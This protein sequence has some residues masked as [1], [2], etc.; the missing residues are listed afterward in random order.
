MKIKNQRPGDYLE[1]RGA[2]EALCR[3]KETR[4]RTNEHIV[5]ESG[6]DE[7]VSLVTTET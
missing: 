3:Q 1:E 7:V 5:D 2:Y 6:C 4:V